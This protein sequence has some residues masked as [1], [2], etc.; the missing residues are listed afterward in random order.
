MPWLGRQERRR[1]QEQKQ[2]IKEQKQGIKEQR[3][4][5]KEQKKVLEGDVKTRGGGTRPTRPLDEIMPTLSRPRDPTIS[6]FPSYSDLTYLV[7]QQVKHSG[8]KS[9]LEALHSL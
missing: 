1:E 7:E 9:G 8:Q 5:I 3:Q 6:P 4:G 2:E